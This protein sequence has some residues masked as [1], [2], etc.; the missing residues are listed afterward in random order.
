MVRYN[1]H[2]ERSGGKMTQKIFE[3]TEQQKELI[4]SYGYELVAVTESGEYIVRD[5][6]GLLLYATIK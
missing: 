1:Y 6:T 2:H 4:K 3:P 5:H